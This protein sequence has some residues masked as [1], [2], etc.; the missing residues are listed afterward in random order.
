MDPEYSGSCAAAPLERDNTGRSPRF[1]PT[2]NNPRR[3]GRQLRPL[4]DSREPGFGRAGSISSDTQTKDGAILQTS[5]TAK[6]FNATKGFGF[7]QPDDGSKDVFVHI[8]AVGESRS[9]QPLRRPALEL[10]ERAGSPRPLR[11]RES[12]SG[13]IICCRAFPARAAGNASCRGGLSPAPP[14]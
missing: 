10:H 12:A 9:A 14:G 11:S 4:S 1:V 13:R 7:I 2:E 5:G 8:S 6:W 3:A